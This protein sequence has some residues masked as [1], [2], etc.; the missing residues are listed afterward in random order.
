MF[1]I[2]NHFVYCCSF[3]TSNKITSKGC[4]GAS[5]T[6][7]FDAKMQTFSGEGAQPP[8]QTPVILA[9]ALVHCRWDEMS[10]IFECAVWQPY[11]LLAWVQDAT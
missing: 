2:I 11:F 9:H 3:S 5:Q 1:K 6:C 4:Q 8:P 10:G 7:D